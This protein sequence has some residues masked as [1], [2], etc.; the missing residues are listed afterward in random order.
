MLIQVVDPRETLPPF[1]GAVALR[2]VD[3]LRV[4]C[5]LVVSGHICFASEPFRGLA[6]RV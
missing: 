2:A 1:A 3:V 4:M 6:A 5:R